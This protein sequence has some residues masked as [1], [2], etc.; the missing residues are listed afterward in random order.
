MINKCEYKAS[1]TVEIALILPVFIFAIFAFLWLMFFMYARI[2]LEADLNMAVM[3][4]S[5]IMAVNEEDETA[6]IMER[7][8]SG[9]I[10]EYPYYGVYEADIMTDRGEITAT[11]SIQANILYGG[12]Q[13]LFTRGMSGT[14]SS[15]SVK[16]WNCP[17]IKRII[18]VIMQRG[19]P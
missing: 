17:K 15:A 5:E 3:E 6:Q 18:S 11:A 2:K 14:K 9:Y 16:Y 8:L 4:V 19:E 13:G 10:R 12:V 7:I 1:T